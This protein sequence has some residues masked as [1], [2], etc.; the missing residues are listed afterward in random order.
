MSVSLGQEIKVNNIVCNTING[1]VPSVPPIATQSTSG[2]VTLAAAIDSTTNGGKVPTASQIVAYVAGNGGGGSTNTSTSTNF[3]TDTTAITSSTA[4]TMGNINSLSTAVIGGNTSIISSSGGVVAINNSSTSGQTKINNTV[5]SAGV[6]IG[7]SSTTVSLLG[8]VTVNGNAITGGGGGTLPT[9]ATVATSGNYNDLINKPTIPTV[10]TLATVA[11]SGSYLDLSNKPTIPTVPTLATVATSGS[12]LDLT[13]KPSIPSITIASAI[14]NAG[15]INNIPTAGQV[16]NLVN[17]LSTTVTSLSTTV[18]SLS[19]SISA[20]TT[21]T[22]GTVKIT[23]TLGSGASDTAA[24]TNAVLNPTT[25]GFDIIVIGGQSNAQGISGDSASGNA[26][27]SYGGGGAGLC[28][29][30]IFQLVNGIDPTGVP[31]HDDYGE[32]VPAADPL[33]HPVQYGNRGCSFAMTFAK[34]YKMYKLQKGRKIL[35]VPCAWFSTSISGNGSVTTLMD[36]TSI[37]TDWIPSAAYFNLF[38]NMVKRSNIAMAYDPINTP[39]PAYSGSTPPTANSN[40][41]M[42][43]LLWHQGEGDAA[44]SAASYLTAI[45]T[46]ID[47]FRSQV[48][49]ASSCPFISGGLIPDAFALATDGSLQPF[50]IDN[51]TPVGPEVALSTSLLTSRFYTGFASARLPY[52]LGSGYTNTVTGSQVRTVASTNA[53]AISGSPIHFNSKSHREFGRRYY[54]AYLNALANTPAPATLTGTLA[55]SVGTY[56]YVNNAYTITI[57][58]YTATS[59]TTLQLFYSTNG[60]TYTQ[61]NSG[62]IVPT[63]SVANLANIPP[64]LL[65]ISSSVATIAFYPLTGSTPKIYFKVVAYNAVNT[66]P[67]PFLTTTVSTSPI[68]PNGAQPV[69]SNFTCTANTAQI[70]LA[71]TNVSNV[72]STDTVTIQSITSPSQSGQITPSSTT[73]TVGQLTTAGGYTISYSGGGINSGNVI[74]V[75]I[76]VQNLLSLA[77]NTASNSATVTANPSIATFQQYGTAT[78]SSIGAQWSIGNAGNLTSQTLTINGVTQTLA[79]ISTRNFTLNSGVTAG[80]LYNFVLTLQ[81]GNASLPLPLYTPPAI[82]I[83]GTPTI[84]NTGVLT[85]AYTATSGSVIT[86]SASAISGTITSGAS[87]T[88]TSGTS[89]VVGLV[90]GNTLTVTL[91]A[92]LNSLTATAQTTTLTVPAGL[93]VYPS[94]TPTTA[95]TTVGGSWTLASQAYGNGT[96]IATASDTFNTSYLPYYAFDATFAEVYGVG[97]GGN[98]WNSSGGGGPY[99]TTYTG[100][101]SGLTQNGSWI[102]IQLPGSIPLNSYQL[103]QNDWSV[104]IFSWLLL[105][106]TNGTA[107]YLVDSQTTTQASWNQA[108]GTG[109]GYKQTFTPT[110][111]YAGTTYSYYRIVVVTGSA[112]LYEMRLYSATKLA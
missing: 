1:Q 97:T 94:A 2:T 90:T 105:G 79:G 5:G 72:N 108:P 70:T 86:Y 23:D 31:N 37:T 22:A 99:T 110:G 18:T 102:Q 75:Q 109:V 33:R 83:T 53:S 49:G 25:T 68:L 73:I 55:T 92:T 43:A 62:S 95:P 6:V 60:T 34:I 65:S 56:D 8:T 112:V 35:I 44:I 20:A 77:S 11:T 87:G 42:V 67:Y 82:T 58:G 38:Q 61:A 26:F 19:T 47:N 36:G 66:T 17:P 107:W 41:K 12:Y 88:F 91:T 21:T 27:G 46:L 32:V 3:G 29:G 54:N 101:T 96:Y 98:R 9:L 93:N 28:D 80:T 85:I 15:N 74:T 78:T 14:D 24:S 111:T 39:I 69:I 4:V 7:N 16:Y 100:A 30:D 50:W 76:S 59:A 57:N 71:A 84:S 106:S 45:Q 63:T 13:N 48:S 10:P 81:P 89:Q 104:S 103:Y 64:A 40:N 52:A 51:R